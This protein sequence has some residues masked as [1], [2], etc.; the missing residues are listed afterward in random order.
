MHEYLPTWWTRWDRLGVIVQPGPQDS[1]SFERNDMY[2]LQDWAFEK[3]LGTVGFWRV[4]SIPSQEPGGD[5]YDGIQFA[6]IL[7]EFDGQ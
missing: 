6:E 4:N 5:Q 1:R 3:G 2:Q 7:S